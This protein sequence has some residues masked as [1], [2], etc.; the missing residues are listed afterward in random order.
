MQ[1]GNMETGQQLFVCPGCFARFGLDFAKSALGAEEVA[2]VLGPMFV[3]PASP[4]AQSAE[5]GRTSKRARKSKAAAK[6]PEGEAGGEAET[7][8][9][10][11]NE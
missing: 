11:A 3:A 9:A 8:P 5:I 2:A 1:I 4:A 10:A 7:P 6:S